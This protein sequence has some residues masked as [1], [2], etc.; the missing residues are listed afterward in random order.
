MVGRS[1]IDHF[2]ASRDEL[3]AVF[4]FEVRIERIGVEVEDID[5]FHDRAAVDV[6]A[7]VADW[8]LGCRVVLAGITFD[9]HRDAVAGLELVPDERNRNHLV[10]R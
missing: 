8:S 10:G 4:Q 5:A 7:S 2:D 9:E 1:R 6:L 3:A